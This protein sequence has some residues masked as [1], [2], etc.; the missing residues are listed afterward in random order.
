MGRKGI[1]IILLLFL[2]LA[3]MIIGLLGCSIRA[4]SDNSF[5]N[6][7]DRPILETKQQI[8]EAQATGYCEFRYGS[9]YF[10]V[11]DLPQEYIDYS[12]SWSTT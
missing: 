6:I 1:E 9:E 8:I 5:S 10:I 12:L 2:L 3:I 4:T 11:R 7:L